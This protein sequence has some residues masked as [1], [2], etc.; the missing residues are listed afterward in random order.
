MNRKA[1]ILAFAALLTATTASAQIS[2]ELG[3]R[4]EERPDTEKI[5]AIILTQ[6]NANERARNAVKNAN[7]NISHDF[8]I[9]DGVAVSIPKVAA[10][11]LANR[12]FVREIQPDYNVKTRL[13]ESTSTVNADE[14]WNQNTTGAGVDVAVLD[15]GIEDNTI[16]NIEDQVDYTGEGTDD[17]NGHGTHVAGTI[18]SPSEEYRGVAYGADL[19][20]VKV[21]DQEGSGSASD[22]IAGLEWAADK[23]LDIATLSLG[24]A[25]EQCDGTSSLSEAVDNTVEQGVTVTV[26]A[27]NNGP[28]SETI[29]APGCAQKPITVGSSSNGEISDF[30]SRGPTADGRTK[31]D[32]VAPGES[33]TSLTKND[34]DS[35][36]FETLSGTSMATPQVA[37]TAALLLAEKDLTPAEVK[38][39]TTYT[40]E[41][42]G[43]DEKD[44]GAGRLDAY[45][46]YQQVATT[47]Q[48]ENQ[49]PTAEALR[50]QV[51]LLN[52]SAG[53]ELSINA[54]DEDNETLNATFYLEGEEVS[55]QEGY[56]EITHTAANLSLN[57]T[58]SWSAEVTDGINTSSTGT[59]SFNTDVPTEENETEEENQT[60]N[61]TKPDLPSQASDTARKAR[62][63]FFNPNSPFYG[64]DLAFDRAS[65][66]VGLRTKESVMEERANEARAMAEKGD[67]KAAEKAVKELRN[68][69]GN[70][71]NASREAKETLN[72]VIKDAPE[73]AKKGLQNTLRNVEKER[74]EREDNQSRPENPGENQNKSEKRN[75]EKPERGNRQEESQREQRPENSQNRSETGANG[76]QNGEKENMPDRENRQEGQNRQKNQEP[77]QR[78]T[79]QDTE[80]GAETEAKAGNV[81]T[82]AEGS[83][84]AEVDVGKNSNTEESSGRSSNSGSSNSDKSNGN[85]DSNSN[86]GRP[87]KANAGGP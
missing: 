62:A 18:A 15:T 35:P 64:L 23:N 85:G 5:D 57:T 55:Q 72:R 82:S 13:S 10:E 29:T 67:N 70:S 73:Q 34:G 40:A 32:L 65:V 80:A 28:D 68:T 12:D 71:E 83:A 33:I 25:V 30:S 38:N 22:V 79:N 84:E 14:V 37:G 20:D 16:L 2:P 4:L 61:G 58:Y 8:N 17:L 63:G 26:A 76:S 44:Q 24:A 1:V 69:A 27:G 11:N 41:D 77:N 78:R 54:T 36:Q 56:G 3:D 49:A 21:L 75:G 52:E 43:F 46:A 47:N 60:R 39:I 53:A 59:Q 66:A 42:L 6:P 31:P 51:K 74:K 86:G 50:T 81:E 48:T 7:G 19:F 45:A 87:S 9:I